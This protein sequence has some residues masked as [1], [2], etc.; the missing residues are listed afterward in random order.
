MAVTAPMGTAAD[1]MAG[2]E[3]EQGA[4]E[5]H[6][7]IVVVDTVHQSY[8]DF[9]LSGGLPPVIGSPPGFPPGGMPQRGTQFC[10]SLP[11]G[12]LP[13]AMVQALL[14]SNTVN[15]M[16]TGMFVTHVASTLLTVTQA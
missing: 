16:Q 15:V 2:A 13:V 8:E 7:A 6:V 14:Y 9:P 11:G 3:A 5:A 10:P 1:T 12:A 4:A